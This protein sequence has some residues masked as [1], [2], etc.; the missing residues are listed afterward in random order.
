MGGRGGERRA[1]S[2]RRS[3]WAPKKKKKRT[4]RRGSGV[5]TSRPTQRIRTHLGVPDGVRER[6]GRRVPRPAAARLF[7]GR[8]RP[9]RPPAARLASTHS[10][11]S[12]RT[13]SARQV[14]RPVDG[15]HDV[16]TRRG[17]RVRAGGGKRRGVGQSRRGKR[18]AVAARALPRR[19]D[20]FPHLEAWKAKKQRKEDED[21]SACPWD[22][23]SP[24]MR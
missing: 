1:A 22:A 13:P 23:E 4:R 12:S 21:G 16:H 15:E 3:P 24:R 11:L 7:S 2:R 8:A 6:A 20:T 5:T 9:R 14:C 10:F 19:T 17:V 18:C